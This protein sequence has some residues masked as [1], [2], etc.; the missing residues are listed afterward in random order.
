M[1]SRSIDGDQDNLRNFGVSGKLWQGV[2]VMFDRESGS[3]WTQLDGR[4]IQGEHLGDRLEHFASEFTTWDAWIAAHPETLVLKKSEEDKEQT[5]SH[6]E[7]YFA[8][9]D[10][11]FFPELAEGLTVLEPKDLIYG[12]FEGDDALAV[13]AALLLEERVVNAVVG[14]VPVALLMDPETGF[15]RAIDRRLRDDEGVRLLLFE[16]YGNESACEFLR[17]TMTGEVRSVD[18]FAVRR[19]DRAYWYA[20]GR[21]HMGSRVLA[22]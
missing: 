3:Y 17:D 6:Y 2:L 19:I 20:W 11:L 22:R 21:S 12:V 13:E 18:E 9:K 7:D 1:Y 15:L 10:K 8:D 14:G 5:A 4:S 16:P